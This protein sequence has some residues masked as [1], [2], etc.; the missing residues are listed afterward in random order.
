MPRQEV[1]LVR[2]P[3][4]S[5]WLLGRILVDGPDELDRL[6]TLQARTLLETPDMRNERRI[7][8]TEELMRQRTTRRPRRSPTGPRPTAPIPSTC[9]RSACGLWAKARSA[10]E[11][12]R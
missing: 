6:R 9:S 8:E 11:T 7:L 1:E 4:N 5:V 10:S 12:V 2:A 3:T